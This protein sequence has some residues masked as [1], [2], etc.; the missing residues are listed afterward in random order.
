[1]REAAYSHLISLLPPGRRPVE[2]GVADGIVRMLGGLEGR[3]MEEVLALAEE[4]FPHLAE[5]LDLHAQGRMVQRIP[6]DEEEA[7][8]RARVVGAVQFWLL[9]GTRKGVE[10]VLRRLGYPVEVVEGPF[11][12]VFDGSW[13]FDYEGA[14]TGPAW[15]EFGLRLWPSGSFHLNQHRY[16]RSLLREVKPAHAILR[17]LELRTGDGRVV[18]LVPVASATLWDM[19]CFGDFAFGEVRKAPLPAWAE[20]VWWAEGRLL[21][22]RVFGGWEFDG[23]GF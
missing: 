17:F 4:A 2:G 6:P 7:S 10:E 20:V 22:A 8:F 14:F 16:L 18:R 12:N 3:L 5:A 19:G 11:E 21:E 1:M 13:R 9:A 15:A 23:R